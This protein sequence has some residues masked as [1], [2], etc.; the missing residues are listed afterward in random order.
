MAE[1]THKYT[2]YQSGPDAFYIEFNKKYAELGEGPDGA[3]FGY[4]RINEEDNV[5]VRKNKDGSY[6]PVV[7]DELRDN[8][9]DAIDSERKR[10]NSPELGGAIVID[11]VRYKEKRDGRFGGFLAGSDKQTYVRLARQGEEYE[12]YAV[13]DADRGDGA[14]LEKVESSRVPSEKDFVDRPIQGN[15]QKGD[16][17]ATA[18][19]AGYLP[20]GAARDA[21][22]KAV[23]L[24]APFYPEHIV[25]AARSNS[26]DVAF[27]TTVDT[28]IG[29]CEKQNEDKAARAVS[30]ARV[31]GAAKTANDVKRGVVLGGA[32]WI[33]NVI[34]QQ[35]QNNPMAQRVFEWGAALLF[36]GAA[37]SGGK[38]GI[39][40]GNGLLESFGLNSKEAFVDLDYNINRGLNS[41]ADKVGFG[42]GDNGL[43][44]SSQSESRAVMDS[45]IVDAIT[46]NAR[47]RDVSV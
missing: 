22:K 7:E 4:F 25:E 23:D 29:E 36:V 11:V 10:T 18:Y 30:E 39:R 38:A 1:K 9:R 2:S 21:M 8:A 32:G 35:F 15:P 40:V 16:I 17:L 19:L 45:N 12:W 14:Y 41:L 33:M 42:G 26:I 5:L 43:H 6:D 13:R 47:H 28:I 24:D 3:D 37:F 44:A 20:E 27:D 34:G 31:E 46:R